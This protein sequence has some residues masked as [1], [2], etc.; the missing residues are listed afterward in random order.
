MQKFQ[1]TPVLP[2]TPSSV[3]KVTNVHAHSGSCG[4]YVVLDWYFLSQYHVCTL[5]EGGSTGLVGPCTGK[6]KFIYHRKMQVI[7]TMKKALSNTY[8]NESTFPILPPPDFF[9]FPWYFSPPPIFNFLPFF[10]CQG[11]YMFCSLASQL[12]IPLLLNMLHLPM[13]E[14]NF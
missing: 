11:G 14:L 1:Y 5:A 4:V 9:S 2:G 6:Q 13:H 12:V 7:S 3:G 10:C 8:L